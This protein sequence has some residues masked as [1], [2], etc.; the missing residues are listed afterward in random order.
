[1]PNKCFFGNRWCAVPLT[2]RVSHQMRESHACIENDG[3]GGVRLSVGSGERLVSL[4]K[5]AEIAFMALVSRASYVVSS[6]SMAR[7]ALTV[8]NELNIKINAEM[9]GGTE[10]PFRGEDL[11][12]PNQKRRCAPQTELHLMVTKSL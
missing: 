5:R 3:L 9:E 4:S 6:G 12:F 1:M 2:A 8:A 11:A 7:R 10:I